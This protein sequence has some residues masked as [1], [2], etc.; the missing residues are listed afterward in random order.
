M[1]CDMEVIDEIPSGS[2]TKTE[3]RSA[4]LSMNAGTAP[5]IDGITV[6]LL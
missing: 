1:I 4:I 5:D 2:I 6:E 3:I